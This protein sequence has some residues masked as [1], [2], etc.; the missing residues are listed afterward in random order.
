MSW[1]SFL[2]G[3]SETAE[4]VVDGVI[5]GVDAMFYTD[6][7]KAQANFQ[8]LTWKLEYAKAT[9][10]QSISRRIIAFVVSGLWASMVIT[11][12]GIGLLTGKESAQTGFMLES[13]KVVND[14]FMII[15][16][17]YFLAHVVGKARG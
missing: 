6:E 2:T 5:D 7:E 17:F 9:Q 1:F 13:F 14:P 16:G 11:T 10:G 12:I 15:I 3:K 8:I 4:K